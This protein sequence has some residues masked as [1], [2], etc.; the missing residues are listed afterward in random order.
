MLIAPDSVSDL[1]G[2]LQQLATFGATNRL[3]AQLRDCGPEKEQHE[4]LLSL[5]WEANNCS[6]PLGLWPAGVKPQS[7]RLTLKTLRC[8]PKSPQG[9][10]PGE[11]RTH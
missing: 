3:A 4:R 8:S 11:L 2:A 10:P 1:N 5:L 9:Q 7:F 6:T